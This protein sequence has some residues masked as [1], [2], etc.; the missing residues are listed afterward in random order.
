MHA[1]PNSMRSPAPILSCSETL[2]HDGGTTTMLYMESSPSPI[3]SGAA[4]SSPTTSN[5]GEAG[6]GGPSFA[7]VR[8]GAVHL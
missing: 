4:F 5:A 3:P 2:P 6:E 1:L 7:V 8:R